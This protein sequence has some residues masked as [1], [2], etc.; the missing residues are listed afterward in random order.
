MHAE[1]TSVMQCLGRPPAA[2][3]VKRHLAFLD[4]ENRLSGKD[5]KNERE[6]VGGWGGGGERLRLT[7]TFLMY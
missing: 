6:A 7:L 1:V 5:S 4:S 2:V 3:K